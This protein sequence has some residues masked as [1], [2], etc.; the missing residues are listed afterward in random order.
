MNAGPDQSVTVGVLYTLSGAS[1]SDPDDVGPWTYSIDWGDRSFTTRTTS[2]QGPVSGSHNYLLPGSYRITLTV[3]DIHG[4]AGTG[5][6]V[7]T[8]GAVS[9]LN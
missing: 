9:G 3:T 4:A 2:S 7:L 6:K 1:F 8:V 5:S